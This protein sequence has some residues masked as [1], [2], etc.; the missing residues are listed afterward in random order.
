MSDDELLRAAIVARPDEDLP[1][2]VYADF[3][4]EAGHDDRAEL[5]R[6]QCALERLPANDPERTELTR[7]EAELLAAH[8]PEWRIAGL[9][10]TQTFRRGMI[11]SVETTAEALV[12][13]DPEVLRLAPVRHL[14]LVNADRWTADLAAL[15][16]WRRLQ[17]LTLNNN[18]FGSGNRMSL[19]DAAD[20]PE[21][22]SLSL[23]NNRLWPE[24]VLS[25]AETRVAGQLTR[26]DLSGNPVGDEG[27]ATLARE[28]VFA[29]LRE[30][31]LRSDELQEADCVTVAGAISISH[32]QTLNSLEVLNFDSHYLGTDGMFELSYWDD[33]DS[34][35]ELDLAFN[36]IGTRGTSGDWVHY[37]IFERHSGSLRRLN[38]AGNGLT[39][40]VLEALAGW[41][42]LAD[43]E[44]ID[45]RHI[46]LDRRTRAVL[47]ASPHAAKFLLDDPAAEYA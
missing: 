17:S 3:L 35:V 37:G 10:G 32:S 15:P 8:K 46:N 23:R 1:R 43:M 18:N 42:H 41:R 20:M 11:E 19:L 44:W 40:Q 9:T 31:I 4:Q 21:L 13:A 45:L 22:R 24:G 5:I 30:L 7:R 47:E 25:L 14:R 33:G 36:D 2:L 28:P 26:L 34:L 29:G 16:L 12:R 6:V 27:V 39:I 38:L